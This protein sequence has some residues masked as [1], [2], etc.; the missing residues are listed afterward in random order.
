VRQALETLRAGQTHFSD[1]R[2]T[3]QR[4]LSLVV[5]REAHLVNAVASGRATEAVYN[6]LQKEDVAKKAI[7][8]RLAELDR[9]AQLTSLD[10]KRL[11]R[12]VV[13]RA[14]DVKALL[15]RSIPQ[16]RQMLRK[17]IEGRIVCAPFQDARGRGYT[18]TATGTYAG[19]L[20]EKMLVKD[21]G[22]GHGS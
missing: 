11:E 5:A 8:G 16:A 14:A 19:L 18:L 21:G 15:G 1:E 13:D 4:E 12:A 22:G 6:D 17:L 9:L 20:N 7:A 3:L 10:A 2:L